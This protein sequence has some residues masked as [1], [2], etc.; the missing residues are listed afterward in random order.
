M[1]RHRFGRLVGKALRDLPPQFRERI[2]N[3]EVLIE[4]EPDPAL[5]ADL[6]VP[7]GSTL[8]GLYQGI[9]LTQRDS[10]YTM[11]IPDRLTIFQ[12]PIEEACASDWEIRHQVQKTV[13]HEI[14]HY[15]GINDQQ[16]REWGVS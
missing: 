5:L 11:V 4:D 10:A 12:R 8:F 9:P 1:N 16:L 15:F 6:D 13:I 14:A 2:E 3:V 7:A